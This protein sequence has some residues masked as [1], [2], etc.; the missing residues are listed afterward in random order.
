MA[1]DDWG[2]DLMKRHRRLFMVKVDEPLRSPGYP[3]CGRGWQDIIE[4]LCG[5][6]E[7]TLREGESFEFVSIRQKLGILRADWAAEASEDTEDTIGQAVNLAI[8]A[9]ACTCES[10]GGTARLHNNK[11]RLE[12]RCAEDAVGE[13]VPPRYGAGFENVHR[14]RRWRG[15]FAHYDRETDTLTEVPAPSRKQEG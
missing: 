12:T 13:I 5:R 1:R 7:G 15:Y 2:L 4:R 3:F 6:I 8:A 11:G 14:F 9:S 10:C